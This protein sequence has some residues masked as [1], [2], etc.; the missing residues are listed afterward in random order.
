MNKNNIELLENLLATFNNEDVKKNITEIIDFMKKEE[1]NA[2]AIVERK[3][4][5][6]ER[7][8]KH[9][10]DFFVEVESEYFDSLDEP[11]LKE[12]RECISNTL[13][14]TDSYALTVGNYKVKHWEYG[15]KFYLDRCPCGNILHFAIENYRPDSSNKAI[16]TTH[17][18]FYILFNFEKDGSLRNVGAKTSTEWYINDWDY[19]IYNSEI[20]ELLDKIMYA[21]IDADITVK[22]LRNCDILTTFH[23]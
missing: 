20:K 15:V 19:H 14:D 13:E 1:D 9:V 2:C 10:K 12:V 6:F 8:M 23:I 11:V 3:P 18:L 22:E 4:T 7:I 5:S 17:E 16:G 21:V